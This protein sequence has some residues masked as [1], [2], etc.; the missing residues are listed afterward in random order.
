[1]DTNNEPSAINQ[2]EAAAPISVTAPAKKTNILIIAII[3][4]AIVLSA[5]FAVFMI[6]HNFLSELS[7]PNSNDL[8][9]YLEKKYGKD[10][11][12][13]V[14]SYSAGSYFEVGYVTYSFTSKKS[15]Q[16]FEVS[17][18]NN[19][20]YSDNYY[21]ILY[22]K[23]LDD[24]Y[25]GIYGK[26]L[27]DVIPYKFVI[28]VGYSGR[29]AEYPLLSENKTYDSFDELIKILDEEYGTNKVDV[30]LAINVDDIDD[31]LEKV[32]WENIRRDVHEIVITNKYQMQ[33]YSG[34]S[35]AEVY[36]PNMEVRTVDLVIYKDGGKAEDACPDNFKDITNKIDDYIRYLKNS[37]AL[38]CSLQAK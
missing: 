22:E 30:D 15:D 31:D 25:Y 27:K 6:A 19:A 4:I 2:N 36:A 33:A 17:Y 26:P 12:F 23:E 21:K 35:L 32:N 24:Y 7:G 1:M 29:G 13:K 8:L 9:S 34:S 20:G 14:G 18:K 10:E 38:I 37:T 28:I 5:A 16:R 3:A 11:G